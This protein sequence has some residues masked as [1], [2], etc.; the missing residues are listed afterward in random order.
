MKVKCG[1][2]QE[3]RLRLRAPVVA[4]ERI[5]RGQPL[6]KI[7]VEGALDE[8]KKARAVIGRMEE[9]IRRNLLARF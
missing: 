6:P 9:K 2:V 7:F 1:L 8:L 3:I 4:L 5:A